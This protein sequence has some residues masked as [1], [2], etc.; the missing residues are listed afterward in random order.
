M[1]ARDIKQDT[2]RLMESIRQTFEALTLQER[3]FFITCVDYYLHGALLDLNHARNDG[4][5]S[6]FLTTKF[7]VSICASP[8][9]LAKVADMSKQERFDFVKQA[10]EN[11]SKRIAYINTQ[12]Q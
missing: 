12:I 10:V 1:C 4:M 5:I 11:T 3:I 9:I 2:I 7:N 8:S 6:Y